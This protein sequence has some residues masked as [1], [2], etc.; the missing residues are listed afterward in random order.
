MTPLL[1]QHPEGLATQ[2]QKI[3]GVEYEERKIDI[4]VNGI[5]PLFTAKRLSIDHFSLQVI[6]ICCK[7]LIL[8]DE[9]KINYKLIQYFTADG[10]NGGR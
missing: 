4:R 9:Q 6:Q 3:K 5:M 10:G 8:L 7:S 1:S 2:T